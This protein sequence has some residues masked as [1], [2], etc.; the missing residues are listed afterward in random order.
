MTDARIHAEAI[1][2]LGVGTPEAQVHAEAIEVLGA[3]PADARIHA[4]AIEVM[5][6]HIGPPN[7]PE[8]PSGTPYVFSADFTWDDPIGGYPVDYFQLQVDD[9]PWFYAGRLHAYRFTGLTPDADHTL[10]VRAVNAGG[11]S[12]AATDVVH[13]FASGDTPPGYYRVE[14]T[15]GGHTWIGSNADEAPDFGIALPLTLGWA[16]PDEVDYFPAQADLTALQFRLFVADISDIADVDKGTTCTFRMYVQVD[17]A[18]EPW[19]Q[20]D[21]IVTQLNAERI[22][23]EDGRTL[24]TVF[25]AD[26]NMRLA[27]KPV[28]YTAIWPQESV[29]DRLVRICAEAGIDSEFFFLGGTT[30]MVGTLA[31]RAI[32]VTNALAAIRDTLKDVANENASEPPNKYYG[33]IVFTYNYAESDFMSANTIRFQPMERRVYSTETLDGGLIEANGKWSK[34]PKRIAPTW[35]IIDGA[36]FGTPD[37]TP[38]FVRN[39][40][41]VD[42]LPANY[43]AIARVALGRSL[44]PDGSTNL[45]GWYARE[46]RYLMLGEEGDDHLD[47]VL[48]VTDWASYAPILETKPVILDNVAERY[49]LN[50][51]AYLAG[52]ITGA[53]LVIPAGGRF[54]MTVRLRPELLSGTDLPP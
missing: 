5:G 14:V 48:K 46:V 19:Q 31:A 30:G 34:V 26:D 15:L 51:E 40:A 28:G 49:R 36:T 3:V 21:G 27:D 7:T 6:V 24:V 38:P 18:A 52:T 43:S 45:T 4:V 8:N 35:G 17:E 53:R 39:T 41:F 29:Y 25:A 44:V 20:F 54:Y 2:V 47:D 37:G 11:A 23:F 10:R 12:A 42:T 22:N 9:G 16:I 50:G 33:R 13:T 32:G 1:E